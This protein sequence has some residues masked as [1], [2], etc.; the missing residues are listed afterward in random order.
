MRELPGPCTWDNGSASERGGPDC[1]DGY[2]DAWLEWAYS[3][4]ISPDGSLFVLGG[5]SGDVVVWSLTTGEIVHRMDRL[6]RGS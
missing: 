4:S 3:G 6:T 2:P 1:G 5:A